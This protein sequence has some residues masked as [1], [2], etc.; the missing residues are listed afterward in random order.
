MNEL[1]PSGWRPAMGGTSPADA[2]QTFTGNRALQLEEALLFELGSP[3]RSGV[4]FDDVGDIDLT[5]L[6]PLARSHRADLPGLSEPETVRHYTRLSR[7]NYAIDLG[8]F[9]LGSCTMKHNP[10]LDEKVARMP[11]FADVHPLQPVHTVQGALGAINEL[12]HWLI[13]LTGMHGV[14][15]T[16]K[17]GAH[18]ELCGLLCIRAALEAKGDPREVILVP[19]S[20]HGTNP[21]TAAFAGYR[22]ENIPATPE[23]RVD[24]AALTARLGPDVAGV[25]ITNPNT[26]GLF[27]RD[28]KTIADAVH[29]A[30]GYVYCDGANFNA[31][32]GRVRP[33]D[34]GVDA[35]HINLHKTFST[36]HGGGGPG[37]GPVVL[38]EALSPFGPL[39]FTARQPDG[40]IRLIEEEQANEEHPQAFGR[41]CAFHGQMG[42]FTRALAYI[43]SHGADGLRQ[44]S[45]DAVLNANY[46]LRRLDDVLDAPF[47]GAGPCMHEALFSDDGFAE[48]F[49]TIDLAKGLIDEGYHPMTVYFPLVVHGAMLVEPT[50][51]ES[52]AGL[53]QF[54]GAMRSLAER[55]RA[56]DQLLKSAPHLAP[57]RRLD[58]TLAA[59][60]PKLVYKPA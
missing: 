35:M 46:V 51:T 22:V 49:S 5:A 28:L 45:S 25:M 59:R 12:A 32:V 4:D 31:I 58:E 36:P 43:L 30:G 53:D 34:L 39:P 29:A 50:E 10:R 1:N 13:R 16:P 38:S 55:A 44:V 7:Q 33:G 20:A 57:R 52:K 2:I 15:M 6:G 40:S 23:G 42:M 19:E 3:D 41:M 48:G 47:G 27:E 18:G 24:L 37:S 8:L 14:A 17:A 26:C 56:G 9:P 11:G 60:K 21:A 54:I